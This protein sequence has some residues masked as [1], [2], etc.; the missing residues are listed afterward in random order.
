MV[1]EGFSSVTKES[2]MSWGGGIFRVQDFFCIT[3]SAAIEGNW[4][5]KLLPSHWLAGATT[6]SLKN[7]ATSG[8]R[9]WKPEK[10]TWLTLTTTNE[11]DSFIQI[12]YNRFYSLR[13]VRY[14][15]MWEHIISH[16]DERDY[17]T[18]IT[19][20]DLL[21][22]RCIC[23]LLIC[24][25]K[26]I[27]ITCTSRAI[28]YYWVVL[29]LLRVWFTLVTFVYHALCVCSSVC[30]AIYQPLLSAIFIKHTLR[31][32]FD[33]NSKT[34]S[35]HTGLVIPMLSDKKPTTLIS[36]RDTVCTSF[37]TTIVK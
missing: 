28:W 10:C 33:A 22:I 32:A 5:T 16:H 4:E 29:T 11:I 17:V 18:A 26:R 8:A 36:T 35:G 7:D 12:K 23:Y 24:Q 30:V 37:L 31:A 9:E 14:S 21:L 2:T 19:G 3:V 27:K 15:V 25:Q 1:P 34:M 13:T 6:W 20:L